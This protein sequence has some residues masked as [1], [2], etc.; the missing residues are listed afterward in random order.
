[1][2]SPSPIS[3]D[4][5]FAYAPCARTEHSSKPPLQ[6]RGERLLDNATLC[7]LTVQITSEEPAR[8][9]LLA[10]RLAHLAC[11]DLDG[12][13]FRQLSCENAKIVVLADEHLCEE[14]AV[15][16]LVRLAATHAETRTEIFA[17][18]RGPWIDLPAL[19]GLLNSLLHKVN[20]THRYAVLR[21][22][23]SEARVLCADEFS[24]RAAVRTG[25]L[26]LEDPDDAL[27]RSYDEEPS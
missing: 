18:D 3:F 4:G 2:P 14:S 16:G 13:Q 24:I 27:T 9:D 17:L 1:M 20:S 10:A 5:P 15:L 22:Q 25:L 8:L 21:G 11:G 23:A 7:T 12:F 19:L 26:E 6:A